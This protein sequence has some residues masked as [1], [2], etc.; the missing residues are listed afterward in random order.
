MLSDG[1]TDHPTFHL[2]PIGM[3]ATI[4]PIP[5]SPGDQHPVFHYKYV[6]TGD[7]KTISMSWSQNEGD[8]AIYVADDPWDIT[9]RRRQY[10]CWAT[11]STYTS[12]TNRVHIAKG[13]QAKAI[14]TQWIDSAPIIGEAKGRRTVPAIPH[15]ALP[16]T[17]S[18][19]PGSSGGAMRR[20]MC[21]SPEA[22]LDRKSVV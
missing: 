18:T 6:S 2:Q 19:A 20:Q 17:A 15:T 9:T 16:I 7:E 3:V 4:T 8:S 1:K 10:D 13:R 5:Q 12:N 14:A 21:Y 11:W 22:P